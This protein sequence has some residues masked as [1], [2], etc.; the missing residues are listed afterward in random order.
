MWKKDEATQTGP[1]T[2]RPDAAIARG[3]P[4][5]T[6]SRSGRSPA[7]IGRSIT[8][9]GEVSGDEDLLIEGRVDGS[10]N[11]GQHSVTVGPDGKVK[12]NITGRVVTVE[13]TVEGDL[14]AEERVVLRSTANVQG[15]LTAPRVVLED[16]ANFRGGVDMS[17]SDQGRR[18]SQ[19]AASN[20]ASTQPSSSTSS[21]SASSA[22]AGGSS[23]DT[24]AEE[25]TS[26]A[27]G[28]RS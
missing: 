25:A 20:R 23:S 3:E 17:G 21:S 1:D 5:P 26:K 16:G 10:V 7:T 6:S 24:K 18:R 13:G 9:K 8:I 15:D 14:V 22:G 11:L 19:P 2:P 12:A 27:S 4:T 28:A